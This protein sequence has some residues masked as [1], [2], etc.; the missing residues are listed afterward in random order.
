MSKKQFAAMML[1]LF[2]AVDESPPEMKPAAEG[3]PSPMGLWFAALSDLSLDQ[4]NAAI[5]RFLKEGKG[6]P[7]I[8]KLRELAG[9]N[10]KAESAWFTVRKSIGRWSGHDISFDP[11]TNATVRQLGGW[12]KICS[13]SSTNLDFMRL[14]FVNEWDKHYSRMKSLTE[15][16]TAPLRCE[17]ETCNDPAVVDTRIGLGAVAARPRLEVEQK[18]IAGSSVDEPSAI[19]ALIENGYRNEK[20]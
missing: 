4:M 19:S 6:K 13:Q 7:T 8:Q 14:Q 17:L 11:V 2:S 18:R 16:E 10:T 3:I 12:P 20:F 5:Q 9:V 1:A 15:A